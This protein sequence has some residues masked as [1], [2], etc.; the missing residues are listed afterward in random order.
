MATASWH[1][2]RV[3]V[4][5]A[6]DAMGIVHA[7]KL[8]GRDA[9]PLASERRVRLVGDGPSVELVDDYGNAVARIAITREVAAKHDRSASPSRRRLWITSSIVLGGVAAGLGIAAALE[10][11]AADRTALDS[12]GHR[13]ADA[14]AAI[15]RARGFGVVAGVSATLALGCVGIAI[16]GAF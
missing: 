6:A 11:H 9:V 8:A 15:T 5:I 14:D 16:T 1:D 7:A 12:G 10:Q 2:D 4:T 13:K 3:D